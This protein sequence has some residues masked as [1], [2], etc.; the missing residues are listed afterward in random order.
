MTGWVAVEARKY[1]TGRVVAVDVS[2]KMVAEARRQA[3]DLGLQIAY[4]KGD[5]ITMQGLDASSLQ[6]ALMSLPASGP[7]PMWLL[8]NG[9]PC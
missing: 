8:I 2:P 6:E 4:L 9:W 5:M 1:T 3:K 7:S